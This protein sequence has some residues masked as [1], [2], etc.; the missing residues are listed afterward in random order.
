MLYRIFDDMTE[1][2]EQE[3][4]RLLPLVS[5]Q[6]R[7]QAL[8]YKHLFG[9]YCCLKSYEMLT[10]LLASTPYTL[11]STP[12]F[13]YNE[14]GAPSLP[15]GPYFSL[16]HSK[17]G[18]AVA[19]S[20]EPIGIDIEAIR[21]LSEGLVQKAMNPQEQ[22]QIAAAANP[23]QECIRLW[24]RKE[25]YVKMQG[26]GIISDMHKILQDTE[27]LQWHEIVD[28]N[29]GYICT[30]CEASSKQPSTSH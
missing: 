21:P 2:S 19:I 26:T 12:S 20:D 4:A 3:I 17:R 27:A 29:K 13:L 9:Q 6:R 11:H 23:E 5:D 22:A 24:T 10:K 18:I 7:E 8:R 30:I 28:I 16:S 15:G 25:A 14:H 1:C